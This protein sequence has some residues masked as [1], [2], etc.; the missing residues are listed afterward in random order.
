MSTFEAAEVDA[1]ARAGNVAAA[2]TWLG[3]LTREQI[4]AMA[5]AKTAPAKARHAAVRLLRLTRVALLLDAHRRRFG[6]FLLASLFRL[7]RL[8]PFLQ[9]WHAWIARIYENKE[10]YVPPAGGTAP[11]AAAPAAAPASAAAVPPPL[12]PRKPLP[13]LPPGGADLLGLAA[14][15]PRGH[16]SSEDDWGAF[17]AAPP[18][19]PPPPQPSYA[20]VAALAPAPAF[21]DDDFGDFAA[22]PP[23]KVDP[24]AAVGDLLSFDGAAAASPAPPAHRPVAPP[25]TSAALNLDA[26]YAALPSG[27][28]LHGG[29]A[30]V[31]PPPMHPGGSAAMPYGMMQPHAAPPLLGAHPLH[32]GPHAYAHPPPHGLPVAGTHPAA[33]HAGPHTMPPSAFGGPLPP[34]PFL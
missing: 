28:P 6:P 26:L 8:T 30:S 33:G 16:V 4:C 25:A 32:A 34:P 17:S 27:A 13:P 1:L 22:A 11:A 14:P 31:L 7:S 19:P 18:P 21:A 29:G 5:P 10:F 23:P 24:F 3:R 15:A 12:P 9:E 20:P 2:A